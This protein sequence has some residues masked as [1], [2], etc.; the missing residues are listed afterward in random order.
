MGTAD[1][2]DAYARHDP[3]KTVLHGLVVKHLETFLRFAEERSGKALPRY[4]AEEC[5]AYLRCGVL[6]HGFGRAR[7]AGCGHDMFV[8]FSCKRRGACPS[9]GGRRMCETAARV[10]DCVL[11]EVMLRQWVLSVPFELRAVLA[12]DPAMLT[13]TSRV[14]LEEL[15][16]WYRDASGIAR[17][18]DVRVE[19]GA[20]TFVHRGGGSLNLHVHLHVIAADGVW[21]CAT[22]GS[23]PTFVAT[24]APTRVDLAG[25]LVRVAHR[26]AK[27]IERA[28]DSLGDRDE[29]LEGCRRAACARGLYGE[30]RDAGTI[31]ARAEVDE[32]RF[33]RRP[34]KAQVA[35]LEGFNLHASVV[36]GASDHEGRERLLRYVARPTV[37]NGRVSELADGRVAWQLKRPGGRGETHRIMDPMEFMARFAALV[38]QPRFPL[39]RYHGV[40]APH[41]P[42]RPVVVP[43][44]TTTVRRCERDPSRM[45]DSATS[46]SIGDAIAARHDRD[47]VCLTESPD[48]DTKPA[49]ANASGRIDWATLMHRVWGW[50]VLACPRCEGRMRF[51]A[52]IKEPDVIERILTHV[53]LST[54]RIAAAPARRWDDTS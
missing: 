25:V 24:R 49:A 12:A 52:V 36:I 26:V 34:P 20:I 6:A 38:P 48:G 22:D 29:A 10:V 47:D 44:P 15:R 46:T 16:R 35:A 37:A 23:T 2:E 28:G 14:F 30:V 11:P 45:S 17:A 31:D 13:L 21:R 19:A 3:T 1:A 8:A 7:C 43:R 50:D 32:A 18:D 4:V 53:G 51:I 5:R 33:G 9:C 27:G 54:K 40:F 41:S 42:W 39:V